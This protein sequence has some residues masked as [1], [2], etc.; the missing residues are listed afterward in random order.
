MVRLHLSAERRLEGGVRV[1]EPRAVDAVRHAGVVEHREEIVRRE[2]AGG[3]RREGAAAAAA[4]G[5]V[6]VHEPELHTDGAVVDG[7]SVRVVH[8]HPE[9]LSRNDLERQLGERARLLGVAGADRVREHHG[10]G[11]GLGHRRHHCAHARL[12]VSMQQLN[13]DEFGETG[14][15]DEDGLE[16]A[17]VGDEGEFA[18]SKVLV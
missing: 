1:D 12:L 8:V 16:L 11:A 4:D 18:G 5:R 15:D 2:V 3:A 6:H 10:I 9:A 13:T 7:A 14:D 17:D